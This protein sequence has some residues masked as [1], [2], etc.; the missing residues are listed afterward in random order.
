[1][2]PPAE[3]SKGL[4]L[5]YGL[6]AKLLETDFRLQVRRGELAQAFWQVARKAELTVGRHLA[7]TSPRTSQYNAPESL[8]KDIL[9]ADS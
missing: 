2:A 5:F 7:A 1:V 8:G 6:T 3:L 4:S 9:A